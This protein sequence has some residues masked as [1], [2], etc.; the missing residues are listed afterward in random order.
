MTET[1]A[2]TPAPPTI[3]IYQNANHVAGILQQLFRQPLVEAEQREHTTEASESTQKERG[4]EGSVEAKAGLK[5]VLHAEASGGGRLGQTMSDL[6]ASGSR[7]VQNFTY[8]QAYYLYLVRDELTRRS[9]LKPLGSST[10]AGAT[11]VGDFV[12]FTATFR[13]NEITALLEILTP[14]LIAEIT[15]YTSRS[16][17]LKKFDA[18]E[19]YEQ[20]KI[21]SEKNEV[22]ARTRAEL[23]R[24]AARAIRADFRSEKTREFYGTIGKGRAT[25][26]A[27]TMCDAGQFVVEDEDRIL[28]GQWTVLGK[29]ASTVTRDVPILE[30][31]KV[32]DRI[33]P[34]SV[35]Y[36]LG[37]LREA[38]ETR[39]EALPGDDAD[40]YSD[41]LNAAFH[42]RIAVKSIK[43]VPIAIYA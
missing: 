21:F 9:L 17:G 40:L 11:N 18:Y 22:A 23:A 25:I 39:S 10:D 20:L 26:T 2:T 34:A 6:D 36:L 32:L 14:D 8:S 19:N 1:P 31:N 38:V 24:E 4:I 28:D 30:R 41:M 16:D 3:S 7:L 43:V 33:K 35:D 37:E 29:V 15:Y 12:E 5:A 27:I 13:A 42:S